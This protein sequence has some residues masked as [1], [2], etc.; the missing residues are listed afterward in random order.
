VG[1][2][3]E[4]T[5]VAIDAVS[6]VAEADKGHGSGGGAIGWLEGAVRGVRENSW[7]DML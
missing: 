4:V 7:E 5:V 1:E 6:K 2:N 3:W